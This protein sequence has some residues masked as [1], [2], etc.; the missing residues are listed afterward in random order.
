MVFQRCSSSSSLTS[1]GYIHNKLLL[2]DGG[3]EVYH[4]RKNV[5][6]WIKLNS[7]KVLQFFIILYVILF[8]YFMNSIEIYICSNFYAVFEIVSL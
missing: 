5:V 7:F 2:G 4:I 3:V 8:N 1:S 6:Y